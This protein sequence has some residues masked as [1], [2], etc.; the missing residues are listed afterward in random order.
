M[1][2]G[3]LYIQVVTPVQEDRYGNIGNK[4]DQRNC[5]HETALDRG[6]VQQPQVRFPQDDG[7]YRHQQQGIDKGG[8]DLRP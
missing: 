2:K 5:A 1:Q 3:T 4:T 8:K 7:A 6:G